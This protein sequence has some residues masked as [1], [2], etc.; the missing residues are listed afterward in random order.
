MTDY[1]LVFLDGPK[2]GVSIQSRGYLPQIHTISPSKQLL[3]YTREDL[4]PTED[5]PDSVCYHAV[6][7]VADDVILYSINPNFF[8]NEK[9]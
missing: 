4:L 7:A 2:R 9:A 3:A 8:K 5:F 6:K 1:T